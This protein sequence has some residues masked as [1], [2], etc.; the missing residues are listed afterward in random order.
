MDQI[1][2]VSDIPLPGEDITTKQQDVYSVHSE[3]NIQSEPNVSLNIQSAEYVKQIENVY[4]QH[5]S[6]DSYTSN[7]NYNTTT[8]TQIISDPQTD[9]QSHH[10]MHSIPISP[11]SNSVQPSDNLSSNMSN[12]DTAVQILQET[13]MEVDQSILDQSTE[14]TALVVP[15]YIVSSEVDQSI[16]ST[17]LDTVPQ[18]VSDVSPSKQQELLSNSFHNLQKFVEQSTQEAIT[19]STGSS[20]ILGISSDLENKNNS[21]ADLSAE[22]KL[23]EGINLSTDSSNTIETELVDFTVEGT[24]DVSENNLEG[25]KNVSTDSE[26]V[27]TIQEETEADMPMLEIAQ[28]NTEN[29]DYVGSVVAS[30]NNTETVHETDQIVESIVVEN[31]ET[32]LQD[33]KKSIEISQHEITIVKPARKNSRTNSLIQSIENEWTIEEIKDEAD[34]E[35]KDDDEVLQEDVI[36]PVVEEPVDEK[37]VDKPVCQPVEEAVEVQHEIVALTEVPDDIVEA[38]EEEEQLVPV[39]EEPK[40]EVSEQQEK[41]PEG[42]I[43]TTEV[44]LLGNINE[45]IGL[46]LDHNVTIEIIDEVK[47]DEVDVPLT[48]E[49][50]KTETI[51]ENVQKA[52]KSPE[53]L[54]KPRM[55]SHLQGRT[56]DHP[57]EDVNTNGRTAPKARLGVKVPYRFLSSQMLSKDEIAKEFFEIQSKR[58]QDTE[59]PAGGDIFFATKLT[60][61]LAS[62]ICPKD[63]NK[64]NTKNIEKLKEKL[65]PKL[66]MQKE[67]LTSGIPEYALLTPPSS[68]SSSTT[69][70]STSKDNESIADNS[71]LL[72]ILEGNVDV[73]LI[74]EVKKSAIAAS[75]NKSPENVTKIYRSK[76]PSAV[77][78]KLDPETEREIALKQLRSFPLQKK[79]SPR[80]FPRGGKKAGRSYYYSGGSPGIRQVTKKFESTID[81]TPV[82]KIK[83]IV[84]STSKFS[85][86][87]KTA[88]LSKSS[89]T[90]EAKLVQEIKNEEKSPKKPEVP[91][92]ERTKEKIQKAAVNIL[93]KVKEN[94]L[95]LH[96]KDNPIED[97][98]DDLLV[99]SLT[100]KMVS[101]TYSRKESVVNVSV[102][103]DLEQIVN[104]QEQ[105]SALESMEDEPADI[106]N[107][108]EK[109]K[110]G[111]SGKSPLKKIKRST[112]YNSEIPL[113]SKRAR[114]IKRKVIWDPAE[115]STPSRALLKKLALLTPVKPTTASSSSSLSSTPTAPS[116]STPTAALPAPASTENIIASPPAARPRGRPRKYPIK[117]EIKSEPM[118]VEEV[119][120]EKASTSS[121]ADIVTEPVASKLRKAIMLAKVQKTKMLLKKRHLRSITGKMIR[122][123]NG[124]LKSSL[125]L[126]KK[127]THLVAELARKVT[128]KKLRDKPKKTELDKLLSDEG[129]V[130][131]LYS[132]RQDA[133]VGR[134]L[135]RLIPSKDLKNRTKA[136]REVIQQ[137]STQDDSPKA[138]RKKETPILI[139]LDISVMPR[140]KSRDSIRSSIQSPPPSPSFMMSNRAEASRIIRRHSSSFSSDC[141]SPRRLSIDQQN[142][143]AVVTVDKPEEKEETRKTEFVD[144]TS[145]VRT[146]RRKGVPIFERKTEEKTYKGKK[147]LTSETASDPVSDRLAN[148]KTDKPDKTDKSEK[149]DKSGKTAEK[150]SVSEKRKISSEMSKNF[151]KSPVPKRRTRNSKTEEDLKE[152][153]IVIDD[154]SDSKSADKEQ[155]TEKKKAQRTRHVSVS[156][157]YKEISL[158]KMD[159]LVQI[160]LT[161]TCT[162]LQNSMNLQVRYQSRKLWYII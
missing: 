102:P 13:I 65:P 130:N 11:H 64:S 75:N 6:V 151:S 24:L 80:G 66:R 34:D 134:P 144:F 78:N 70:A 143:E 26:A 149:E 103:A 111:E 107:K 41:T 74:K 51:D 115:S 127:K 36:E 54:K 47:Q 4:E 95:S 110:V 156:T 98:S 49:E 109:Q 93:E 46:N 125:A 94:K 9:S 106:N 100:P 89:P 58:V 37:P 10:S 101:K 15:Q 90:K 68:Q 120:D 129:A 104:D 62:K 116:S 117:V 22:N 23:I 105:Q 71:D 28:E 84:T 154:A 25:L 139:P 113:V 142:I 32:V 44:I 20:E 21:L 121:I 14:S 135:K 152:V 108:E 12:I 96:K 31:V 82:E 137:T 48:E 16:D 60:Q 76:I 150:I 1:T 39:I 3:L 42:N 160:I 131:M 140:K 17:A 57:T 99:E 138:L 77:V 43:A 67:E 146:L 128:A 118:D 145:P 81:K 162:K 69:V 50:I 161:P 119:E 147:K 132:V 159:T 73:D 83:E 85:L 61:R 155:I 33:V 63:S 45:A 91:I 148:Q 126:S 133:K 27:L 112:D 141:S 87:S 153:V 88:S 38:E 124:E 79:S 158:R 40:S 114:I 19:E 2:S 92:D 7:M 5:S 136:L 157:N 55:P 72:A 59:P 35:I 29:I 97:L 86:P 52:K 56:V 30:E 18:D 122:S 8:T 53:Q 123:T